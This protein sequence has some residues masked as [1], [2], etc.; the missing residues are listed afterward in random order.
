MLALKRDRLAGLGLKDLAAPDQRGKVPRV[1]VQEIERAPVDTA[2]I[3]SRS[4]SSLHASAAVSGPMVKRSP[5][6]IRP[7]VGLWIRWI[8]AMSEKI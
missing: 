4:K 1:A 6:G 5:T 8:S 2:P 3:T 7:T